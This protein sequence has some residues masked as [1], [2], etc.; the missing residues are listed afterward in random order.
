MCIDYEQVNVLYIKFRMTF[1]KWAHGAVDFRKV[2]HTISSDCG[3]FG[4]FLGILPFSISYRAIRHYQ[5]YKQV[6]LWQV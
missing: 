1:C 2:L 5:K 6:D 3:L 4:L